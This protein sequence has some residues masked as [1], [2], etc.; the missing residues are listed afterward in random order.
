MLCHAPDPNEGDVM[1]RILIVD[2]DQALCRSIQ[3]QLKNNGH[4]VE[5]ELT[6]EEGV[7]KLEEVK[8]D[9]LLLDVQLPDADGISLLDRI[10]HEHPQLP[11]VMITGR[12]DTTIVIEAMKHGAI[13]YIRKPFTIDE[14]QILLE[15]L[16]RNARKASLVSSTQLASSESDTIA[17]ISK[18]ITEVVKQVGVLSRTRFPVIIYGESGTG[19]ELVARSLHQAVT[20]DEPFVAVNCSAMVSSLLE[21]ELFGHERGAFTGADSRRIG[22]LEYAGKGT[23]FLDEIGEIPLDFQAKLLRVIQE[24]EF[25]RV[26]GN[27][28]IPFH[29]RIVAATHRDMRQLVEEGRFRE[30]LFYRLSVGEIHVPPLRERKDD[31]PLLVSLFL[32]RHSRTLGH[33]VEGIEQAA[34]DRLVAHPFPGNV[35]EL[36]NIIVRAMAVSHGPLLTEEAI[37]QSIR[38]IGESTLPVRPLWQEERD[39]IQNALQFFDFNITK[40]AEALDISQTTLRKKIRDYEIERP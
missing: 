15:K 3:L 34:L 5:F 26:G 24:R 25:Q 33:P 37:T 11:V 30:D 36:E 23:F 40:T 31:I 10:Q 6:G 32:K 28:S 16:R 19:K 12:E 20:P 38:N 4:Q 39:A 8:P 35:R 1:S 13:D 17:G 21:T 14:I 29:A 2:D 22:K 7:R 9:L 18:G 27:S